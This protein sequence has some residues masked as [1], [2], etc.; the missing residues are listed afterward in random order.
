MALLS[1]ASFI[2]INGLEESRA[3]PIPTSPLRIGI[4]VLLNLR[5]STAP[6]PPSVLELQDSLGV[7]SLGTSCAK[8]QVLSVLITSP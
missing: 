1:L 5:S 3:I 2:H 8:T 6:L 4:L 7:W